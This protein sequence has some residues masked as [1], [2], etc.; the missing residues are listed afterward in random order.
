MC[1]YCA[2]PVQPTQTDLDAALTAEAL[3]LVELDDA[4]TLVPRPE[5]RVADA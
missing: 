4:T 2:T 5:P 1:P 3:T